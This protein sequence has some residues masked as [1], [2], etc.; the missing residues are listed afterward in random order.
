MEADIAKI[1]IPTLLK[2]FFAIYLSRANILMAFLV[3]I[4]VWITVWISYVW[5]LHKNLLSAIRLGIESV[6]VLT[7]VLILMAYELKET[8][9]AIK[10]TL[11]NHVYYIDPPHPTCPPLYG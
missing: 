5:V 11:I 8:L 9:K 7:E 3:W 10:D 6:E 4:T 1:K 2:C